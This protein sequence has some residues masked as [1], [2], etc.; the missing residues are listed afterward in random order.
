[1]K[2]KILIILLVM[3]STF[4]FAK[5]KPA[6]KI[7][8]NTGKEVTYQQMID[9]II[10]ADVVFFGEYHDNA[11]SHWLELEV[12]KS[13]FSAFNSKLILSAEMFEADNQLQINEYLKGF[14]P[15]KKLEE[16]ARIWPNYKTDYKPLL[17]FAEKNKLKFV[18]ANIPRRYASMVYKK[19]L[20]SLNELPKESKKYIAPLP[21]KYDP[22][23][24]CYK[25][26][27]EMSGMHSGMQKGMKNLP[28]SQAIK[29]ATMAYFINKNLHKGSKLI[30]FNGAYH[31]DYKEGTVWYLQKLNKNLNIVNIT[32]ATSDN[33]DLKINDSELKRADFIIVVPEDMTKTQ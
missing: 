6:Y 1:M 27:L 15:I 10:K 25:S 5:N 13:L 24:N 14:Y 2:N 33:D 23:L 16:D 29:D 12:T 18:A 17:E 28:K 19:G 21:I 20:E 11:I 7:I 8:D 32:T 30:H 22:E 3:V 26:M 31:S 4:S 9:A